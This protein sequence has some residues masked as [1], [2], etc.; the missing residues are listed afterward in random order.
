M[1][2]EDSHKK[3]S[4]GSSWRSPQGKHSRA[5]LEEKGAVQKPKAGRRSE[6]G[7][8]DLHPSGYQEKMIHNENDVE[9]IDVDQ[10]AAR[11]SSRLGGRKKEKLVKALEEKDAKILNRG[12]EE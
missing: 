6:K 10:E 9:N 8:R 3:T 4:V 11:L 1:S 12:E 7:K 5:R 2:R